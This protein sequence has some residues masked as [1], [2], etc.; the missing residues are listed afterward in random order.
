MNR[1]IGNLFRSSTVI[2]FFLVGLFG[3]KVFTDVSPALV[4]PVRSLMIDSSLSRI[5]FIIQNTGTGDLNW[6]VNTREA[7]IVPSAT[8]GKTARQ[9][10][11]YLTFNRTQIGRENFSGTVYIASDGGFDSVTVAGQ[12]AISRLAFILNEGNGNATLTRYDIASR[13]ATTDFFSTINGRSL[14]ATGGDLG[15]FQNRLVISVTGAQTL[16]RLNPL[17]GQA[18]T[19]R[20]FTLTPPGITLSPR[21]IAFSS[22]NVYFS[23]TEGYAVVVDS[24][25][26]QFA[27]D[28][29]SS[30]PQGLAIQNGKLYVANSGAGDSAVSILPLASFRENP[31]LRVGLRPE[32]VVV[33]NFGDVYVTL[34][35]ND[36]LPRSLVVIGSADTVKRRFTTL[37]ARDLFIQ[38]TIGYVIAGGGITTIDVQRDS[39]LNT[40]FISP[41]N[42]TSL[43]AVGVDTLGQEL[44]CLDQANG[45]A[46]Q[47]KIFDLN[48]NFRRAFP[49]GVKPKA[50]VFYRVR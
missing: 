20:V 15:I 9:D 31:R 13:E 34:R 16:E 42:F 29:L 24:L 32:K 4:L 33:D 35:G 40:N 17:T 3:C 8:S 50:I 11:L 27:A 41:S 45:G 38:N 39:I 49:A 6:V 12:I 48:G 25:I 21:E 37:P 19:P 43:T 22:T 5:G 30:S 1:G 26:R 7:W 10:T 18:D 23:A 47:V 28:S 44:Y 46:G 14:G 2:F 36:T